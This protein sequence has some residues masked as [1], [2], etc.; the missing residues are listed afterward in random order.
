MLGLYVQMYPPSNHLSSA[1]YLQYYLV[2]M[3]MRLRRQ[4][5]LLLKLK[6]IST[7]LILIGHHQFQN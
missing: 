1:Y 5:P 7:I 4:D 6:R 3:V 2:T